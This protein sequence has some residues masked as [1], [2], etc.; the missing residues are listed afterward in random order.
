MSQNRQGLVEVQRTIVQ[1]KGKVL[2][3]ECSKTAETIAG[4]RRLCRL[5]SRKM[6]EHLPPACLDELMKAQALKICLL[7]RLDQLI[8]CRAQEMNSAHAFNG[9]VMLP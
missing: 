6:G 3:Q 7:H 2:Q 8:Q 9:R 4:W 5:L 1:K